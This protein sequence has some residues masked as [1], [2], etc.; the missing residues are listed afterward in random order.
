MANK[1][2][3]VS[4]ITPEFEVFGPNLVTPRKADFPGAEPKYSV[5]MPLTADAAK[6]ILAAIVKVAREAWPSVNDKLQIILP[7]GLL[8]QLYKPY[9]LGEVINRARAA[10]GKS[11]YKSLVGKLVFRASSPASRQPS[12]C[13]LSG[14]TVGAGIVKS[15]SIARAAVNIVALTNNPTNP[16]VAMYVNQILFV[17][18][19][20]F[21]QKL[22][23][24][25]FKDYVGGQSAIDPFATVNEIP[26]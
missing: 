3:S 17:K 24:E 8:G 4:L 14:N 25:V 18:A 26:Y 9:E 23:A 16:G 20:E 13:D 15:G 12:I 22:A 11:E 19:S 6:D 10:K 21:G 5:S 2:P 1:Y 7:N